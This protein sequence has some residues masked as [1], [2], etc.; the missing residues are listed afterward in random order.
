MRPYKTQKRW[1]THSPERA[2][3]TLNPPGM[4]SSDYRGHQDCIIECDSGTLKK[5][6]VKHA[7]SMS[8]V[9]TDRSEGAKPIVGQHYLEQQL[10]QIPGAQRAA[11][12]CG[13]P[14]GKFLAQVAIIKATGHAAGM[15]LPNP[16]L[17]VIATRGIGS[18]ATDALLDLSFSGH[19]TR[20]L[21]GQRGMSMV[22]VTGV[23]GAEI[24]KPELNYTQSAAGDARDVLVQITIPPMSRI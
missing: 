9:D 4:I 18:T 23:I 1:R 5:A 15:L 11:S 13:L 20:E 2:R 7:V 12:A 24:G 22:E 16:S 3:S 14:H 10:N 17:P 19:Q 6:S 21:L 8:T